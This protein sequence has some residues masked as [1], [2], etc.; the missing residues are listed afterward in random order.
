MSHFIPSQYKPFLRSWY[1]FVP[2]RCIEY[3]KEW[4]STNIHS[5]FSKLAI[6]IARSLY[7]KVSI[8]P[9]WNAKAIF[10]LGF[11]DKSVAVLC[12]SVVGWI[13]SSLKSFTLSHYIEVRIFCCGELFTNRCLIPLISEFTPVEPST[14][15]NHDLQLSTLATKLAFPS[16]WYLIS[17]R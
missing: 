1:I 7:N 14:S 2:P 4:T 6:I 10:F 15:F 11:F 16:W 17:L 12:P 8:H 9:S 13:F 5:K 3:G